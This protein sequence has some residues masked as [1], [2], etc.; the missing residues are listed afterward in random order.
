MR[1]QTTRALPKPKY[2]DLPKI[3]LFCYDETIKTHFGGGPKLTALQ[4]S[5]SPQSQN[6]YAADDIDN[7]KHDYQSCH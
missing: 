7:L 5:S 3:S 2:P 1:L 4:V 6:R